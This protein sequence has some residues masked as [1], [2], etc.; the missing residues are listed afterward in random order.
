MEFLTPNWRMLCSALSIYPFGEMLLPILAY[1]IQSWRLL[2]VMT[3]A[4]IFL[5]LP[6]SK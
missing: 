2:T 4:P 6:F 5:L 1:N 3:G